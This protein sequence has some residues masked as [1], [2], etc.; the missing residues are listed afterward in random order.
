MLELVASHQCTGAERGYAPLRGAVHRS[1]RLRAIDA[2]AAEASEDAMKAWDVAP[3]SRAT[4]SGRGLSCQAGQSRWTAIVEVALIV[5]CHRVSV[6]RVRV[7]G[8][9]AVKLPRA[10]F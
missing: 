8:Q 4:S 1:V 6:E 2:T 5:G 10:R 7:F 9:L 3:C